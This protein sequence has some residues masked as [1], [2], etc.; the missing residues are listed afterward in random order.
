MLY[1]AQLKKIWLLSDTVLYPEAVSF[2]RKLVQE[3]DCNPLPASQ[4][5]GL[6]SIA[7]SYKYDQLY[8]YVL[9]QRERDWP[10]ARRDLKIFYTE[11]ERV[12]S[13]MQRKRLKD[14]F[15]LLTAGNE[16]SGRSIS[17]IRQEADEL[18]AV[19]AQE[20]IQHLLAENGVLAAQRAEERARQK[21]SRR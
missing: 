15:H 4:V 2:L 11:L 1:A 13:L 9:H 8:R 16:G 17:D 21:S 7:A 14:E 3:Q 10:P 18:M 12:L 6:L 5:A 19:L 20:F